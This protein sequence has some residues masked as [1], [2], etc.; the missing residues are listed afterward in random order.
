MMI[1][2]EEE[3]AFVDFLAPLLLGKTIEEARIFGAGFK[4][5]YEWKRAEIKKLK[6]EVKEAFDEGYSCGVNRMS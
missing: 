3:K 1:D 4:A 6:E 2:E 5:C